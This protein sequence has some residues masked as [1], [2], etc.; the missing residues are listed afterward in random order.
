M[1]VIKLLTFIERNSGLP[2][3]LSSNRKKGRGAIHCRK[4]THLLTVITDGD[5]KRRVEHKKLR[6]AAQAATHFKLG[7]LLQADMSTGIRKTGK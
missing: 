7:T 5:T 2:K 4:V 3:M 6:L 1:H